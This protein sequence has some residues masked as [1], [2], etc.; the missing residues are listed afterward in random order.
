MTQVLAE[1]GLTHYQALLWSGQKLHPETPLH[2]VPGY[3][4]VSPTLHREHL[5]C[6]W[7]ALVRRSDAL[8]T[9]IVEQHGVPRQRV[10]AQVSWTLNCFDLS[11]RPDPEA[12]LRAW[13]IERGQMLFD[14]ERRL[15]DVA[16]V[17][18]APD[19]CAIYLNLHHLVC[20]AWSN[21][22]IL[23]RLG[24]YYAL[25]VAGRLP[26][27]PEP[28][29]RFLDYVEQE[30]AREESLGS[31]RAAAYWQQAARR[32]GEPLAFYGRRCDVRGTRVHR[33]VHV[34]DVARS[35]G[36]SALAQRL[37]GTTGAAAA[38][39]LFG[40]LV[41]AFL[42]GA[43]SSR[44]FTLG[45]PFHNRRGWEEVIGLLMQILP[46]TVEVE[47]RDTVLALVGRMATAQLRAL[48]HRA[49]AVGNP[50]VRRFYDVEYNYI[51]S[52]VPG[53][54]SDPSELMWLH[55]G[56]S[57]NPL[58]IQVYLD[59][60]DQYCCAFDFHDDVFDVAGRRHALSEFATLVNDVLEDPDRPLEKLLDGAKEAT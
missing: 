50:L 39:N 38:H 54:R 27:M 5:R 41:L 26:E 9:V 53:L 42:R 22:L 18:L 35:A 15:F 28:L 48:R 49:W 7:A 31:S 33:L 17:M 55:S 14:L 8:R 34:I 23:R 6:A 12:A 56:H 16:L 30:A 36:L 43:T 2:N 51:P 24:E 21:A 11:D 57:T 20:D 3:E 44:V 19:R 45:S 13:A 10:L 59:R 52:T 29:P 47:A 60:R 46:V 37:G 25:S 32:R 58:A 1:A 4:I 40:A